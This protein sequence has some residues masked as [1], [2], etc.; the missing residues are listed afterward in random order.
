MSEKFS[1]VC[2]HTVKQQGSDT[3]LYSVYSLN[4]G[5]QVHGLLLNLAHS[6]VLMLLFL[7]TSVFQN[8]FSDLP[9]AGHAFLIYIYE[10]FEHLTTVS[11][12]G[13]LGQKFL[14]NLRS[15]A[16]AIY[17]MKCTTCSFQSLLGS[18]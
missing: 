16:H 15:T 11:P 5:Q 2:G 7:G 13:H 17:H 1:Y 3:M 12:Q 4:Q 10:W 18:V 6:Y 9:R 8:N 14:L